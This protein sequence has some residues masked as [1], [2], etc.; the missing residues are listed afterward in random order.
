MYGQTTIYAL[1]IWLLQCTIIAVNAEPSSALSS[2]SNDW[3]T[4][5]GT[6]PQLTEPANLPPPP[7]NT[8]GRV[9]N[10]STIRQT[11]KISLDAETIRLELSNVF[12]GSDLPITAA[13]LALPSN[14]TAGISGIQTETLKTLTF[15]GSESFIIPNGAAIL[16]D[17]VE[18]SVSAQSLLSVSLYLE[19]GQ[20]TNSITSHPGS[21][22]TSYF[23]SGNHVNDE[24][25][26]GAA[27]ADHWYF[28]SSVE[29]Y[30]EPGASAIAFVGDS[31][32]DGRGSTVNGN[33]R[34][35]DL[36][37]ARLQESTST[38]R[39][40]IVNM[41]A[42][43]NRILADGLGPN[44]LGRLDRDVI[45]HPGVR[46]AILFEGVNDIGTSATDLDSQARIGDRLIQAYGQMIIRL[47]RH[48]IKVIGATITPM[49]G[50]GQAYGHPNRETTRQRI[51][52]WIRNDGEFD[53]VIDFDLAVRNPDQVDQLLPAYDTGD[54]LHLNPDGYSAM[55]AAVDLDLFKL[56]CTSQRS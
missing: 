24:D 15:S 7:Y 30:V 4:L 17:P 19:R 2:S 11:I 14:Q 22:T 52:E 49:S 16:S 31:I 20:T 48:K 27:T 51:N 9:F 45:S 42:G 13:T 35:P 21:R 32:T 38:E 25:F 33:D 41:A 5:W 43:G 29:G 36:L 54:H 34:W 40:S 50:P 23:V 26:Q 1:A 10:N 55:A 47:R 56:P 6:M 53:A 44:A 8:T 37:L 46:F 28:I 39:I 3:V 18:L 12:G